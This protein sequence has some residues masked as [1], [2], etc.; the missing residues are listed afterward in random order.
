MKCGSTA[1]CMAVVPHFAEKLEFL[2]QWSYLLVGGGINTPPPAQGQ[3]AR[4]YLTSL[5]P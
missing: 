3:G 5:E 1:C 2:S 4:P